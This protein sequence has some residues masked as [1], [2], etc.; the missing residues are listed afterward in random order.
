MFKP[1]CRAARRFHRSKLQIKTAARFAHQGKAAQG[2]SANDFFGNIKV[3]ATRTLRSPQVFLR[4]RFS[5]LS[6]RFP[7]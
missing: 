1:H 3:S 4:D 2:Q 5:V 6:S 7:T